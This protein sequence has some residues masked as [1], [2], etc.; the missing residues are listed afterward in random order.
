MNLLKLF[1]ASCFVLPLSTVP[2]LRGD[3]PDTPETASPYEV[4][5]ISVPEGIVLEVG[6]LAFREDG[7]LMATTRRGEI[8][9]LMDGEWSRFA[10]GLDEPLGIVVTGPNEVVVGQRPELTRI[11]DTNGDGRADRFETITDVWNYSGHM[12]EWTFGPVQD[13]EGNF[14]GA[15]AYWFFASERYDEPPYA[16]GDIALLLRRHIIP[17]EGYV[18]EPEPRYRGW[19]FKVTPEGEFVPWASGVRSPNGIGFNPEGDLFVTDNQGEYWGT[20]P[21]L[22]IERGAFYGYPMGLLWD[23]RVHGDPTVIPMEELRGMRRVSGLLPPHGRMGQS[24]SEP[25]WDETGGAFGPFS[26]QMF[27]GDQMRGIVIRGALEKVDGVYQGAVF[28]FI[29]GFQSGN[30]RLAFAP[31]GSLYVGQTD[32]G[33]SAVGGERFGL[34]R[35]VWDGTLPMEIHTMSLTEDGFELTF[36]KPVDPELASDPDRYSMAHFHYHYHRRYGSP[37]VDRTSVEVESASVSADGK[38]VTLVLPELVPE[39]IYELRLDGIAS[40]GGT[41]VLNPEAYYTL[42]RLL[43]DEEG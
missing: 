23:D 28:P 19:V 31:D 24:P 42:N 33:W 17:P 43:P 41:P 9:T 37:Q 10:S 35:V 7:A 27:L 25:L 14:W 20:S 29:D 2:Q 16:D 6:G 15:L 32:R 12:Y 13:D 11:A 30:N 39:K 21:V 38:T 1:F 8:W 3:A 18:P 22:H 40:S 36:T 26:G 4:E 34:Q 5:T